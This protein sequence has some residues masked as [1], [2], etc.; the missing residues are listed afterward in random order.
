MMKR[1]RQNN[2]ISMMNKACFKYI[3]LSLLLAGLIQSCKVAK[4]YQQPDLNLNDLYRGQTT[5]DTTTI[6]NMPWQN[7]FTDT[8]LK[9]LILEGLYQNLDLK[10]AV[11]K[12]EEAQAA[13]GQAKGALLPNLSANAGAARSKQSAAA[14]NLAPGTEISTLT[15]TYQL[16]LSASWEA[17][18]WG[19]LSSSK[20]AAYANLLQTDAA[21]RAI[22]TRLIADIANNYYNLLA[23]DKELAITTQTLQNRIKD[24]ETMKTLKE[25]AIVNGAAV[26]QSEANRYAAEVA[27][28]DIKRSI[29]E[30]ENAL[31]ILLAR[32]P[33][34][35]NRG[36][37]D[38]QRPITELQ[39]GLPS[40]L[41]KNRPD[42]QQAEYSFRSA[43]E[44]T[45]VA[46]A[47]FY[48][49]FTITAAGG[50]SNLQLKDFF[51]NSIFY[52]IAAGLTQPIFNQDINKS[53]LKTAQAQQKEAL[54]NYQQTLL[55]AGAE[56]S[57][58]LYSYQS[59]LEKD[60]ARSKQIIALQ[61][62]VDYTQELL[63][64]SSATNYTDV[65]TSEQSLLAAQLNGVNDRLQ[66]LQAIVNLYRALGG[67]WK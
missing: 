1:C 6:A 35:L 39:T 50:Y 17:D 23:L 44:N 56:V 59:A 27:I 33:G 14:L 61:K 40:Q 3:L 25:A 18:I 48:P 32:Q 66:Q 38:E 46:H 9:A 64:Y 53:R 34:P 67:G 26:V 63:R 20:R 21:K 16:G 12:I 28:P 5:S 55:T 45:N 62:A 65:L 51:V 49:S 29:R 24:V 2:L 41:L 52:N 60:G 11:Q 13:L 4:P 7:L 10:T 47:Y 30:T 15:T 19:K 31:D 43:F 54:Y 8:V 58:A 37:L 36:K 57:N 22:Q 42:I